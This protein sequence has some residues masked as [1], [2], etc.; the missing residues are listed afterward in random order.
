MG[1]QRTCTCSNRSLTEQGW[2]ETT[3]FPLGT[4]SCT[5]LPRPSGRMSRSARQKIEREVCSDW[6]SNCLYGLV[7]TQV[8]PLNVSQCLDHQP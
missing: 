5:R 6:L 8:K 4:H 2:L 7:S 1:Y 3:N